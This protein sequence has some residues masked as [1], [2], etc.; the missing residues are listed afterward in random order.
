MKLMKCL[1]CIIYFALLHFCTQDPRIPG[2]LLRPSQV[3]AVAFAGPTCALCSA[4]THDF[5]C[6]SNWCSLRRGSGRHKDYGN[7]ARHKMDNILQK[8]FLI[9]S[10][11]LVSQSVFLP[12]GGEKSIFHYC[13]FCCSRP[14]AIFSALGWRTAA[15]VCVD[16]SSATRVSGYDGNGREQSPA[17]TYWSFKLFR[18]NG[19]NEGR[20]KRLLCGASRFF[21]LFFSFHRK[22]CLKWYRL[23]SNSTE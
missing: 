2:H 21:F 12:F 19:Q 20:I 6:C 4:R 16:R 17:R 1:T 3:A 11:F 14:T 22:M 13:I 15:A 8:N 18:S 23:N 10:A 7:G 9:C 5:K